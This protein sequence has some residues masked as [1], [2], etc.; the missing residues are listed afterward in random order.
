MRPVHH[1]TW[2]EFV[3]R[4]FAL[5]VVALVSTAS[6]VL[7]AC[8]SVPAASPISDPKEI[9]VQTLLSLKNVKTVEITGSLSGNLTMPQLGTPIDLSTAT[10]SAALDVAGKAKVTF[11][12]PTFL[13]T[14]IDALVVDKF[15]YY[16]VAGP[17]AAMLQASA[18]RYTKV[19]VPETSGKPMTDPVEIAKGIDELR[20]QLDKLPTPPTKGNDEKCG[21]QDC[22]HVTLNVSAADLKAMG[23]NST[24]TDGSFVLDIW[25]RK[26]DL[27][28]AKLSIST[29]TAQIGTIGATLNLKY[30]TT[31][32]VE[33]PPADQVAP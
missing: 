31:V 1:D 13:G 5:I 20:A 18:D 23:S 29:T 27:R 32:P 33:A 21:D 15:A 26:N 16:K 6:L 12:A 11:D 4:R 22:Y 7:A 19:A 25:S 8:N 9:V 10:F 3:T 30:D 17:L 14:K 24:M 2:G 28:P